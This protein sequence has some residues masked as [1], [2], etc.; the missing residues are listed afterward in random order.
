[1]PSILNWSVNAQVGGGPSV[2]VANSFLAEAYA[3]IEVAVDG[4]SNATEAFQ[5]APTDELDFMFITASQYDPDDL[6]FVLG[7]ET[8]A[9]DQPQLYV[10]AGMLSRFGSDMSDITVNN[11]L[12]DPVTVSVLVGRAAS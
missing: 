7:G 8:V 10:G 11:A 1:M 3:V 9:L 6:E 5:A 4:A 12:A 2:S